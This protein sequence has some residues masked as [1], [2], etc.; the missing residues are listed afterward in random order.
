M[1]WNATE[2]N[3]NDLNY[4]PIFEP[5]KILSRTPQVRLMESLMNEG[6]FSIH[7]FLGMDTLPP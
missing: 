3:L 7:S 5:M 4:R 1:N 6:K 2:I